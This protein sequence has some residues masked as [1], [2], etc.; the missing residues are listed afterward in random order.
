MY[1]KL[2]ISEA[3]NT[4]C[5]FEIDFSERTKFVLQ[6]R[7]KSNSLKY[8]RHFSI[9]TFFFTIH[10]RI[11]LSFHN[12]FLTWQI[13]Y[14]FPVPKFQIKHTKSTYV[15]WV[16]YRYIHSIVCFRKFVIRYR[17]NFTPRRSMWKCTTWWGKW[18]MIWQY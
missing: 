7:K 3:L 5:Y 17:R 4:N 15:L 9:H 1:D 10:I 6:W 2:L 13:H 12:V 16:Q 14:W 8:G 18:M 11:N